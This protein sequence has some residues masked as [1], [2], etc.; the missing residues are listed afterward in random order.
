MTPTQQLCLSI[1]LALLAGISKGV[2][3]ILAHKFD[4]SIFS[5][6]GLKHHNFWNPLKS[7]DNKYKNE[8]PNQGERF[9][10]SKTLFVAVTDGWHLSQAFCYSL[11]AIA[12]LLWPG[13]EPEADD[14]LYVFNKIAGFIVL[15]IAT[16]AAF[17]LFYHKLLIIPKHK[18]KAV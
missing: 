10:G 5:Y 17:N 3:D 16:G 12:F 9:L 13:T 11:Q 2:M 4:S 6:L 14:L 1:L 8:D 15:R 18:R 7:W